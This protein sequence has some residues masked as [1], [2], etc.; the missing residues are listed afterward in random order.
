MISE[1]IELLGKRLYSNIPPVL[2]LKNVPTASE[3]D[4]VGS[5][6]FD[7][8]MIE[9]ILPASIEEEVDFNELLAAEKAAS[10]LVV[11]LRDTDSRGNR[12]NAVERFFMA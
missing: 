6:D 3:L 5:E 9:T 8:T 7:R 12:K 1:K 2:T 11:E 4:M 10:P